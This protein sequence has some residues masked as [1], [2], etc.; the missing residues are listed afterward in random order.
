[1]EAA[2]IP[3][4]ASSRQSLMPSCEGALL[5]ATCD[6]FRGSIMQ[7]GARV[8]LFGSAETPGDGAGG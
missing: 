4:T 8:A 5:I 3:S 1:M 2:L 6:G 7:L